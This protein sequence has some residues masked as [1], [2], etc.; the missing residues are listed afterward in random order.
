MAFLPKKYS[1]CW[2]DWTKRNRRMS[3][4]AII[5]KTHFQARCWLYAVVLT[6]KTIFYE[7]LGINFNIYYDFLNFWVRFCFWIFFCPSCDEYAVF[8]FAEI[9]KISLK[10][11]VPFFEESVLFEY[12]MFKDSC[13]HKWHGA[14]YYANLHGGSTEAIRNLP[15]GYK[16]EN[17]NHSKYLYRNHGSDLGAVSCRKCHMRKPLSLI[18]IWRCRRIER[19]RSRWSPYH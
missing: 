12:Q 18:H 17:W 2:W 13:G 19:C 5:N 8:E 1:Y 10:K 4:H 3:T 7:S 11:D 9:V 16:P 15:E 6:S 14:I